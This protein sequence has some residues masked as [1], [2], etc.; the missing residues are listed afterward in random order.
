MRSDVLNISSGNLGEVPES[1]PIVL[2]DAD[3]TLV[4]DT[5]GAKTLVVPDLGGNRTFTL[6]APTRPGQHYH[7]IYGGAAADASNCI[8]ATAT[9]NSVYMKGGINWVNNN[10]T[11]DDGI[12]VWSDGNSNELMTLVTPETFDIHFL[13][14]STTVWYVWGWAASVTILTIGD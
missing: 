2:P 11:S 7:F 5:H 3:T 12:G 4:Y 1:G 10:D 8:F 13:A 14:F 9:D 6:P